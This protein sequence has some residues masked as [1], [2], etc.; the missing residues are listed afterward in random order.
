MVKTF[1]YFQ[2]QQNWSYILGYNWSATLSENVYNTQKVPVKY[3]TKSNK[4]NYLKQQ[5]SNI[6]PGSPYTET[7]SQL[8]CTQ[9]IS[10]L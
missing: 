1:L 10:T 5:P 2:Q 7:E 6:W 9:H 8:P 4:D 3:I